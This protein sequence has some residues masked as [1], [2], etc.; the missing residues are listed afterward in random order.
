MA[1]T[2]EARTETGEIR[3]A[4]SVLAGDTS[5][6]SQPPGQ[7]ASANKEGVPETYAEFKVPEGA[8]LDA[9]LIAEVTPIF[10]ELGLSQDA[11]QKL[12][13]FQA[14][15]SI[16]SEAKLNKAV[17]DMRAEWR[18]AI[19]ADPAIGADLEK[20]KTAIGRLKSQLP[21]EIRTSFDDAM[22]LTGMGDH[23]AI[24]RGLFELAKLVNE[25]TPVTGS[26]PSELGQNRSGQPTRPTAAQA[27]YPN[28]PH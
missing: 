17:A 4:Q 14:K 9:A 26:G 27:L 2:P 18:D 15:H 16:A 13:E 25:G 21:A 12:V 20:T 23:P 22:N 7:D 19:K 8:T 5:D 3:D 10:K 6:S 1:N 24:V 11:A 28:L